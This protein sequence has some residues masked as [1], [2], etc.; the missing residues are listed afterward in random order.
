MAKA[1]TAPDSS[2]RYDSPAG[3]LINLFW[4]IACPGALAMTAMGIGVGGRVGLQWLDILYGIVV[5][6]ALAAR[7]LDAHLTRLRRS[8]GQQEP[9]QTPRRYAV[10]FAAVAVGVWVVA[11]GVAYVVGR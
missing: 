7:Y 4:M 5:V 9:G 2:P 10:R 1:A 8:A 3:C 6:L 11:H